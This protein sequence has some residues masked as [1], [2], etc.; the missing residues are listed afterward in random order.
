MQLVIPECTQLTTM[1]VKIMVMNKDQPRHRTGRV[2]NNTGKAMWEY[3]FYK[4]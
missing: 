1:T 4:K 2:A 3:F